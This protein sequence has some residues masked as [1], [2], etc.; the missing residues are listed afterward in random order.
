[1]G[2]DNMGE[3]GKKD[4]EEKAKNKEA[5]KAERKAKKQKAK[6]AKEKQCKEAKNAPPPVPKT[7]D[8]NGN[9][10]RPPYDAEKFQPV[11]SQCRLQWPTEPK[12]NKPPVRQGK[13]HGYAHA[14]FCLTEEGHMSIA[15]EGL[16]HR[17]ELRHNP[18]WGIANAKKSKHGIYLISSVCL[19]PVDKSRIDSFTFFQIHT[20]DFK[21]KNTGKKYAA[22]PFLRLAWKKNR[23]KKKDTV[24]A[25]VREDLKG[26]GKTNG[27]YDLDLPRPDGFFDVRIAVVY[28]EGN[29]HYELKIDIDGTNRLTKEIDYWEPI[30]SNYF[31]AGCYLHGGVDDN[32]PLAKVLFKSLEIGLPGSETCDATEE[33]KGEEENGDDSDDSDSDDDSD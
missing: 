27:W 28:N 19:P 21:D 7:E 8:E 20:H 24:W 6:E 15:M 12:Y 18:H 32:E 33:E 1:M 29:Q 26:K 13:F 25:N 23:A 22:G 30:S 16:G 14:D 3:K 11:L 5:R 17:C 9:P 4:K 2:K 10:Y 31:K